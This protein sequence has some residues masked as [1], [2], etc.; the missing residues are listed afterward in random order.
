M[1]SWNF[2]DN[3]TIDGNKYLK[4][5]DASGLINN[6]ILGL[7]SLSNLNINSGNGD[8][9]LN[10]NNA[11]S[12]TFI[13]VNNR[14][15]T[16]ISSNLG[17]GISSTQNINAN[18]TL[19]VNGWIGI[20]STSNGYLGLSS[21]DLL[22]SNQGSMMLLY[23]NNNTNGNA[24][25][26]NFYAGSNTTSSFNFYS[27]NSNVFQIQNGGSVN[28]SPDGNTSAFEVS[29]NLIVATTP[30]VLTN[31]TQST[32]PQTG[33]LQV[34]GGVGIEGNTYINGILTIN[35]LIGNINFNNTF[36]STSYSM[37]TIYISG[38]M[39]IECSTPASSQTSGG[40]LSVAGGLALGKNAMIG[41]NV[42]IYD[43]TSSISSQTGSFVAYGGAGIN[44]QVNLKSSFSPQLR[45]APLNSGN[46]TSL[47]FSN[48]N[49][50]TTTGSWKIGN[51]IQGVSSGLSIYSA[52]NGSNAL[53][54]GTNTQFFQYTKFFNEIYF[55]QNSTSNFI[56][57]TNNSGITNW[58]IGSDLTSGNFQ[59][60][61][62]L[63]NGY[64]II[65]NSTTGEL[66]LTGTQNSTSSTYG[67]SLTV[68]GGAAVSSDFYV[69]GQLYASGDF[70]VNGT[71]QG[72]SSSASQFAY[73]TLTATD[74]SINLTSGA[75]V[76]YG[77]IT[78]QSSCDAVSMTNGGSFLTQGGAA[79][80]LSLYVGTKVVVGNLITVPNVRI[81][82]STVSN[83][84]VTNSTIT[85]QIV[86]TSSVGNLN[87]YNHMSANSS[88]SSLCFSSA[89]GSQLSVTNVSVS[90]INVST[91]ITSTNLYIYGSMFSANIYSTNNTFTNSLILNQTCGTIQ[92]TGIT[93]GQLYL[94]GTSNM[95]FNSNTLGNLFTTGG[96]VGINTHAPIFPLHV[97]GS[98]YIPS[99]YYLSLGSP[100]QDS[101]LNIQDN[102]NKLITFFTNSLKVGGIQTNNGDSTLFFGIGTVGT[103]LTLASTHNVGIGTTVPTFTL[104][105]FGTIRGQGSVSVSNTENNITTSTGSFNFSS[106]L[107]LSNPARNSIVY[108]S[109]GINPPSLLTRSLGTKLVLNPS[110]TSN[111]VDYAIGIEQSNLW[112]S[113]PSV[114]QGFKWYQGTT[115]IMSLITNG[116]LQI[117]STAQSLNGSTGCLVTYGGIT[118][119]NSSNATSVSSG[120]AL[121][122]EGGASIG[123]DIYIGG[124]SLQANNATGTISSLLITSSLNS[125]GI[126]SGGSLTI[127]GGAAVSKDLYIGA[128]IAIGNST[129]ILP[130]QMLE[131]SPVSYSPSQDGG[132]RI[133]TKNP[134][135][136]TDA[137]YRYID[138]RLKSDTSLNFRGSI[139]GTLNG[140]ETTEQEYISF[141]QNGYTYVH[142][143]TKFDNNTS[144]SNS[145]TASVVLSGGLSI[146]SGIN[147][148]DVSN[149]GSLTVFGGAS[150]SGD[151]IVGGAITYSNAA[152]ASSTFAYLTLTATDQS[153]NVGNGALV[154]FGGISIQE[155]SDATSAT[156]GYGLTVAGGVGIGA[157]LYVGNVINTPNLMATN[158]STT[159]LFISNLTS[160]NVII[161]NGINSIFDSNTI[162][163]IYTTNGN[164]GIGTT[165]PTA[166]LS[167]VN[168]NFANLDIG[169]TLSKL[170]FWGGTNDGNAYIQVGSEVTNGS[171]RI[172][173]FN[174][175]TGNI[176]T[177]QIF[178]KT[179]SLS[180]L[181]QLSNT[182]DSTNSSTANIVTYGG[183][184]IAKTTNATSVTSGGALTVA[185]GVGI[186]KDVYVGGTVTSSSDK[187]LKTNVTPLTSLLEKISKINPIKYNII[188]DF[189]HTDHPQTHIGFIA[190]DF[191]DQFPELL[192]RQTKTS[193]YSLAYDRITA[194]NLK[195]IQELIA[196]NDKL[197]HRIRSIESKIE[198]L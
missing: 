173:Q 133:S 108:N 74:E 95:S 122:V 50:Y 47:Y 35:S 111:T 10:C 161:T 123:M 64:N 187:R 195:C 91:G 194:I 182:S 146:N 157:S 110:V 79:I 72:S 33:C 184:S 190:Q 139:I 160:A 175:S 6:N 102:S 179:T 196:E 23:S 134:I 37:G 107:V 98:Q 109:A 144:C 185:G 62:S 67:G 178:S 104:D 171:L 191:E 163:N 125:T 18:I 52:D 164:V 31:T 1:S 54:T 38:G 82:N 77:G 88:I 73:L 117:Y 75:L 44:G 105:V 188:E 76:S 198:Q 183:I 57:F 84:I 46:E 101:T 165:S 181:L 16:L 8:L 30:V 121:T 40:G 168:N 169:S 89:I 69:G 48:N 150:I 17:V 70:Q 162:G 142:S 86:S 14:N 42:T 59:L 131:L 24:G 53:F 45:I 66:Q 106:D 135:S 156:S 71:L 49:N 13:N 176:D 145:S 124:N 32:S 149:G 2:K 26:I 128:H 126:G 113:T 137:S 19:P 138:I 166:T 167:I 141:A 20:N 43:S 27:N 119:S 22:S 189:K 192:R 87:S 5:L 159:N 97:N 148:V 90:S 4:W 186:S 58:K 114:L 116:N 60:T 85:N 15:N 136:V 127:S 61:N 65:I 197:K 170:R 193:H 154:T 51:N 174:S 155:T 143:Q 172:S 29:N 130:Q 55:Q 93:S 112:Y 36:V 103:L 158:I 80:G 56:T 180:G 41:G 118:I 25:K 12:T 34:A 83:S 99:P 129:S 9:Y 151:L 100:N 177:F 7:D 96:N 152:E 28:F 78:I 21:S 92:A 68:L 81:S 153:V 3:L 147:A 63:L 115:N 140:G 39:G 120:Y 132:L 11:G 94:T